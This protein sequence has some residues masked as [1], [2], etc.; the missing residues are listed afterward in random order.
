MKSEKLDFGREI[1]GKKIWTTSKYNKF[2]NI[3]YY[4]ARFGLIHDC[5]FGIRNGAG[6]VIYR[7]FDVVLDAVNHFALEI[8]RLN[9]PG[10]ILSGIRRPSSYESPLFPHSLAW[11]TRYSQFYQPYRPDNKVKIK[12][13]QIRQGG[14]F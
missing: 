7:I 9:L 5:F 10:G 11:R 3:E 13:S 4:P 2:Y 1:F 14:Q 8:K 6:N 12:Y